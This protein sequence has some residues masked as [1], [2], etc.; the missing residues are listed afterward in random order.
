[1]THCR[2]RGPLHAGDFGGADDGRD[3]QVAVGAPRRPEMPD[4]LVGEADVE[5]VF[6]DFGVHRHRLD[7]EFTAGEDDSQC[8]SLHGWRRGSF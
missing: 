8:A 4:V 7:A 2:R 5:R 3:T 1:M 6:V